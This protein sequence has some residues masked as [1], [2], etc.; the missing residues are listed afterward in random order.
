VNPG[1]DL[2][3]S[4]TGD[5]KV[6]VQSLVAADQFIAEI[7][8][9]RHQTM[10]FEPEDGTKRSQEEYA[11]DGSEG[12]HAFSKTGSSRVAPSERPLRFPLDAW[13]SL[14]CLEEVH[15]LDGVFNV[16]VDEEAVCLAV[17][18]FDSDLKAIEASGFR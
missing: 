15:L 11:F 2:S 7:T 5:C 13:Y 8:E 4:S 12:N 6:T 3:A 14:N 9:A 16:S 17:D 18:V 10:L 1:A